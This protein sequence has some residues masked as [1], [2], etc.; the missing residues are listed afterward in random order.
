M[1]REPDWCHPEAISRGVHQLRWVSLRPDPENEW[2]QAALERFWVQLAQ[3]WPES[4]LAEGDNLICVTRAKTSV[5]ELARYY[6]VGE[7]QA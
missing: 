2:L 4:Y 3:W 5:S 7:G 1:A 6:Q